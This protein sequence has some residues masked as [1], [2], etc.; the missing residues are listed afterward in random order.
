[1]VQQVA[2]G[3]HDLVHRL[4]Q[5]ARPQDGLEWPHDANIQRLANMGTIRREETQLRIEGCYDATM[6][7]LR[8]VCVEIVENE[9]RI[10]LEVGP[11][12]K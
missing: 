2:V 1:M 10:F 7:R 4:L 12:L 6:A 11:R 3:A 5:P 9:D 8:D